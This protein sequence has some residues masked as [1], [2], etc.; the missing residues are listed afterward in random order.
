MKRIIPI[1][2]T[3]MF[4]VGSAGESFTLPPSPKNTDAYFDN[5]FGTK[6]YVGELK[7]GKKRKGIFTYANGRRVKKVFR[8]TGS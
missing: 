1:L 7:D 4:F 5:Y 8:K 6:T 3:T 2:L